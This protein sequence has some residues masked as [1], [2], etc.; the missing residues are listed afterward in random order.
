[1]QLQPPNSGRVPRR[2]LTPGQPPATGQP[3]DTAHQVEDWA[4]LF[5]N[6]GRAA[7]QTLDEHGKMFQHVLEAG[8]NVSASYKAATIGIGAAGMVLGASELYQ[9]VRSL[10]QGEKVAGVLSLAGGTSAML[11]A[12]ANLAQ[13]LA[14]AVYQ[15]HP[16]AQWSAEAAG[17]GAIC[18]GIE[19]FLPD[20]R[21]GAT[22]LLGAAKVIS[23]G[24]L[25]SSGLLANA[26][27]QT[28]GSTLYVG[29]LYGQ[30]KNVVDGWLK[31]RFNHSS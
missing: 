7:L 1:M 10:R 15:S 26:T 4:E 16:W 22:P 25:I 24:L 20:R 21:A 27:L 19:D 23:G 8:Q 31:D 3:P 9:G 13:G 17:V 30:Y 14:P 18:D 28:V 6:G 12:T 29:I 5:E 11:G 2:E